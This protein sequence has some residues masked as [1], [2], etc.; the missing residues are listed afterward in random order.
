MKK[1]ILI[2][3]ILKTKGKTGT[4][5]VR[6][7]LDWIDDLSE[8][9]TIRIGYSLQYGKNYTIESWVRTGRDAELKLKEINSPELAKTLKDQGVF[10]DEGIFEEDN[11]EQSWTIGN[12]VGCEVRDFHS[13]EILGTIKEVLLLPA[14]DVWIIETE[15][16]VLPIPCIEK[17]IKKVEINKKLVFI[18]LIDGLMDLKDSK[19]IN[20]YDE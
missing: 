15:N 10:A 14:N 16:G 11:D 4:F 18:E 5:I 13:Q 8:G 9:M 20:E 19:H 6:D 17:V 3:T 12:I 1:Y 2:G 7:V